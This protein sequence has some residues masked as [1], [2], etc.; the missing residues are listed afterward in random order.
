M[1]TEARTRTPHRFRN[2]RLHL[3]LLFFLLVI[4]VG[5][6]GCFAVPHQLQWAESERNN[7]YYWEHRNDSPL[8]YSPSSVGRNNALNA[9]LQEEGW[10]Y[11]YFGG[12]LALGG[13]AAWTLTGPLANLLA[14][15]EREGLGSPPAGRVAVSGGSGA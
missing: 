10:K 4:P 3:A 7:A 13:A 14:G 11:K 15:R 8:P 12:L 1:S 6:Y 9:R 5:Y 2:L